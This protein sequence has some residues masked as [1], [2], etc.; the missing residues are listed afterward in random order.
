[1]RLLMPFFLTALVLHGQTKPITYISVELKV[2]GDEELAD[3]IRSDVGRELRSLGDTAVV[4]PEGMPQFQIR[5]VCLF[6]KNNA[7]QRTGYGY[8]FVVARLK[9]DSSSYLDMLIKTKVT[10]GDLTLI[11]RLAQEGLTIE[12]HGLRIGSM[13]DLAG[14]C[15]DLVAT[16]DDSLFEQLRQIQRINHTHNETHK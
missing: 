9:P 11:K 13:S 15:Q 6:F 12:R 5:I 14:D 2:E 1:M 3:L 7:G 10:D 4:G 8:S 16:I